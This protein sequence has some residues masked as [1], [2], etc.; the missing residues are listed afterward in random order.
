MHY[1]L[2]LT[3]SCNMSCKYCYVK[4]RDISTMDIST[5][6]KVIELGSKSNSSTGIVFFGG[7]PLLHKDI[8]YETVAYARYIGRQKNN[9]YH[10]KVITNGLLLDEEF[11][12]FSKKES[13]FIALSHDGR[14]EAH[15]KNR[16]D[17]NGQGTFDRLSDKISLL[18]L[19]HPYAPVMTVV[20][21]NTVNN[22]AES[23]MYLYQRGFKYIINSI[24]FSGDWTEN[25]L[26]ILK[27]EYQ[28]ITDFYYE[29]TMLEDKFYIEPFETK[30]SS[31]IKGNTYCIDQCELG[32]KQV[33][34][35]PDGFI[36]PCVQFVGEEKYI[37]GH[38][39]TGISEAKR[40]ELFSLNRQE[41]ESCIECAVRTRCNHYCGCLNKHLT[42]SIDKVSPIVCAHERI[43][44]PIADRLAEKLYKK[45]SAMFIQKHYNDIY[46]FLSMIEDST[47]KKD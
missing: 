38:V 12:E 19:R 7:E 33:S 18:L 41:K 34:I 11:I 26:D 39:D 16:V 2:H 13:V 36:Y 3:N 14:R 20:S 45:R 22:F 32:K 42:G 47:N 28:K 27:K 37:I 25:S 4:E 46:P 35:S 10:F 29:K 1:T 43:L 9:S 17:R 15:D 40:N 8:I 5:A 6:K 44:L 31:H 24:N 30:I 21:P 23:V